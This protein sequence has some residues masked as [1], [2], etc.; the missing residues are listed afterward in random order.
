M[1]NAKDPIL[2]YETH[3]LICTHLRPNGRRSCAGSGGHELLNAAKRKLAKMGDA[4]ATRANASGCLGRCDRGPIMVIYPANL[5]FSCQ[6][7][8][9]VERI[10]DQHRSVGA[11]ARKPE[12][13]FNQSP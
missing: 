1:D 3:V 4:G 7:S 11:L 13:T 5:W 6:T 10:L 8:E 2:T 12:T 9:Q